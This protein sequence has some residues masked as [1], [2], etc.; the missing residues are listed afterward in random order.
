M[1]RQKSNRKY[2]VTKKNKEIF[3]CYKYFAKTIRKFENSI[4]KRP[5]NQT[6]ANGNTVILQNMP[7]RAVL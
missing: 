4:Q 1:N 2:L 5:K 6:S 3:S 7:T